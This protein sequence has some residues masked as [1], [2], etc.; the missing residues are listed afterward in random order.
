MRSLK[1]DYDNPERIQLLLSNNWHDGTLSGFCSYKDV[2]YAYSLVNKETRGLRIYGLYKTNP[3]TWHY[4]HISRLIWNTE[5]GNGWDFNKD[6]ERAK[7]FEAIKDKNLLTYY[8]NLKRKLSNYASHEL[9]TTE[10]RNLIGYFDSSEFRFRTTIHRDYY[11]H[12][13][14]SYPE[15]HNNW[16]SMEE[17]IEYRDDSHMWHDESYDSDQDGK[18]CGWSMRVSDEYD[19]KGYWIVVKY[20]PWCN[21]I[22]PTERENCDVNP[23]TF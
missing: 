23:E 17:F 6:N 14:I 10:D 19:D 15:M 9:G 13:E 3:V 1:K 22:M 5:V 12:G 21:C 18:A 16:C 20:C 2:I 11:I 8:K 4:Y 7:T